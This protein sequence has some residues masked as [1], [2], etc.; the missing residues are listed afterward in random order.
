M[1]LTHLNSSF[2]PF[3]ISLFFFL[4]F[5]YLCLMF[6]FFFHYHFYF[7]LIFASFVLYFF[8]LYSKEINS[9]SLF[10]F[11]FNSQ[12]FIYF[13][14]SEVFFFFGVFWSLFWIIFSYESCFL[15]SLPIIYPFGLALFNTFLL[16]LSSAYAV[17]YHLN[18]LNY[19]NEYSLYFCIFCGLFFLINQ[20]IEFFCCFFSISDFS[21]CSIF[22]FGT[23]FHG[24]HVF[25]GLG[26]LVLAHIMKLYLNLN[27]PFYIN[28]ALL[29]WHFVDV[30]WLFLFSF[31]YIFVYYLFLI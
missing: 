7:F 13:V 12:F 22:F 5:L 4:F 17:V 26:F 10:Q 27:Y 20:V 25:L 28:C 23:G 29:Y 30:V 3:L 11:Y 18:Y 9:F 21:F 2:F 24:F 31:I 16:L 6:K 8:F 19:I 15:L 1:Y 14:L